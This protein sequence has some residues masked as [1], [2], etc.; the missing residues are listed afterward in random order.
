MTSEQIYLQL[1][2]V[3]DNTFIDEVVVSPELS[4]KDVDEWDSLAH[5]SLVLA[6]EEEFG[7]RFRVGEVEAAKNVGDLVSIIQKHLD[8]K[9]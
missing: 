2:T 9:A 7:L 1:Q 3:F 5:V 8:R 4:A 6:I